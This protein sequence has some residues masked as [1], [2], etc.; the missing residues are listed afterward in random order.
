[1]IDQILGYIVPAAYHVLPHEMRSPEA[2][3]AL[4]AIGLQES[5]FEARRQISGPARS[6]WQFEQAGVKG[7]LRHGATA[8]PIRVALR[9]LKYDP[10]ALEPALILV[11]MEHNDV[12]AACFARCLLWTLPEALPGPADGQLAWRQ[13]ISAWQPGKPRHETWTT[14]YAVAWGAVLNGRPLPPITEV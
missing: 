11:A 12:L 5:R 14:N 9:A 6:F 13:Y 4:L 2:T 3:A 10:D 7:V 8:R 1:M